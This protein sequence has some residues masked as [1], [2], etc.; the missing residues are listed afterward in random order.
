MTSD[1]QCSPVVRY[2]RKLFRRAEMEMKS[3]DV[4]RSARQSGF[5]WRKGNV[6]AFSRDRGSIGEKEMMRHF[7]ENGVQMDIGVEDYIRDEILRIIF[8]S[9]VTLDF[10]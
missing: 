6:E 2:W 4:T 7:L 3:K 5:N 8:C 10:G 1:Q 9:C